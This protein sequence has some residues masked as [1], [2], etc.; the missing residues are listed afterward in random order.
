MSKSFLNS[1]IPFYEPSSL[2]LP[3]RSNM[4]TM[5]LRWLL[6]AQRSGGNDAV[7]NRDI[8]RKIYYCRRLVHHSVGLPGV[9]ILNIL[10]GVG[11]SPIKD[12]L[13]IMQK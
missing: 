9:T 5:I 1:T 2:I 8:C 6:A 7:R 11:P 10:K 4:L 13:E 12:Q 3:P